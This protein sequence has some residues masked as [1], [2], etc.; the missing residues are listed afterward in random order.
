MS[1]IISQ[2]VTP[3]AKTMIFNQKTWGSPRNQFINRERVT[4]QQVKRP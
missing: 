4:E 2:S 1:E 3:T